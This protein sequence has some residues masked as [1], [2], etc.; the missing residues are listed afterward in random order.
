MEKCASRLPL[1]TIFRAVGALIRGFALLCKAVQRE[2]DW[3]TR[4]D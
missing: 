2:E 3:M 4:L 1:A